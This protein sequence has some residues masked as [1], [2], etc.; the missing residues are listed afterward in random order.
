MNVLLDATGLKPAK[1]NFVYESAG[2]LSQK[3]ETSCGVMA[4]LNVTQLLT[5]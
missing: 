3:D 5:G 2:S 4:F 1:Q